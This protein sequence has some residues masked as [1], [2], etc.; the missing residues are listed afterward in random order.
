MSFEKNYSYFRNREERAAFIARE[1][2]KELAQSKT[3]L[4]VGSDYNTLKKILG[5]KV[6]GVDL[7]GEPDIRIDFEKDKLTRFKNGQFDFLVCTEVLEHL[8]NLHEMSDE[9]ARVAKRYILVS[10]P[11]CL[12]LFAKY[13]IVFHDK[14]GKYYGLPFE[15]P[16]DRHRWLFSYK[17]IDRFFNH[18]AKT[19]GWKIRR[20]FLQCNFTDSPRGRLLRFLVKTFNIDSASQ[21]Y[22][23]LLEKKPTRR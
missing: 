7:Y 5:K 18:F 10:L 2:A 4:D 6:T 14:I 9:L 21:S 17:D 20:K 1:F 19:K 22:W 23:I 3:V 11:N 16:E 13:N 12:S 8:D 15:R